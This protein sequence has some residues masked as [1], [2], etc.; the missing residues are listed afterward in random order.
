MKYRYSKSRYLF[1]GVCVVAALL[2][3]LA[4]NFSSSA[5]SSENFPGWVT[6]WRGKPLRRLELGW[7]EQNF[8]RDFPGQIAQ[9]SDGQRTILMRYTARPTR[10]LHP[11]VDC[12]KGSGYKIQPLDIRV[13]EQGERWGEFLAEGNGERWRV[14]ERIFENSG[15]RD[16]TDVSSW[17][18]SAAYGRSQGPWWAITVMEKAPSNGAAQP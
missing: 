9:F 8:A 15:G 10:S 4:G 5:S 17:Y 3:L 16:W 1:L 11:A 14:S 18:W 6:H 2:P 7:R 13:D 12:F